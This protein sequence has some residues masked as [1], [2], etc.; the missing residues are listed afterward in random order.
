M[1]IL[2]LR[3]KNL[4]SLK[5]EFSIDFTVSPFKD[6][7]LFAITGATGAGKTT[8]LDAICLALYHRTPRMETISAATNEL[9][10]RGTADCLAEVEFEVKGVRYRA[11]WSQRRAHE[12]VD[13]ALQQPKVELADAAGAILADKVHEKKNRIE[14]ITGLS[15][16]RFTK[17]VLL[18]QGGFA[19][20]LNAKANERSELLEQLTGTDIYSRISQQVFTRTRASRDH[21]DQLEE[22]SRGME[23]L[24]DEARAELSTRRATLTS[25]EADLNTQ[26]ATTQEQLQWREAL[27]NA[28]AGRQSA[29]QRHRET[30]DALAHA[31]P[32]LD[33]LAASRPAETLRPLHQAL[34]EAKSARRGAEQ[35][36]ARHLA[37]QQE[38]DVR[39]A[40]ETKLAAQ[41]ATRVADEHVQRCEST[42]QAIGRLQ[43]YRENHAS[44]AL[45][46]QHLGAWSLQ[47]DGLTKQEST[48]AQLQQTLAAKETEEEAHHHARQGILVSHH[49]KQGKLEAAR[50][51]VAALLEEQ[52]QLLAGRSEEALTQEW[53][54]RLTQ[55]AQLEQLADV[56]AE[57]ARL[58]EASAEMRQREAATENE[59]L[60]RERDSLA[61]SAVHAN[62]QSQMAD[63]KRLLAQEQLIKS[64]DVHREQLQ[65]GEECPLCGSQEHPAIADYKA[66]NVTETERSLAAKEKELE[67]ISRDELRLKEE[68][69]QLDASL[70]LVRAQL[71]ENETTTKRLAAQTADLVT[72]LQLERADTSAIAKAREAHA[73]ALARLEALRQ[74]VT[75]CRGRHT[76]ADEQCRQLEQEVARLTAQVAVADEKASA[77]RAQV[78]ELA[79][80]R[81][82]QKS[83]LQQ[84]KAQLQGAL[85]AAGYTFPDD[86]ATWLRERNQDKETWQ[87]TEEELQTHQAN[88]PL[89]EAQSRQAAQQAD[90]LIADWRALGQGDLPAGPDY[91][92]S[93]A[94]LERCIA[95]LQE[96]RAQRQRLQGG[97]SARQQSLAQAQQAH[98]Q[99]LGE[100]QESLASSD[101]ADE[102]TFL[103][104]LLPAERREALT[105]LQSRLEKEEAAALA[106]ARQAAAACER[107]QAQTLTDQDAHA[108]K[109]QVE[110]L[111]DQR[112]TLAMQQGRI[113]EAL[114]ADAERRERQAALLAEIAERRHDAD[115]WDHLNGLI[116]SSDGAK[117]RRFAQGLTLDHLVHLANRQLQRLH[118]RY[119]LQ[120]RNTGELELE[121]VDTW[122]GDV[123]RDTK[124]LSGGES[125]LVSLALALALSDLVSHKTS[126]DSLFLDEGF[127]TLDSETLEV[128][129]A[130]LDNLNASGKTI[131][132][133]SHIEAM[134]ERINVQIRVQKGQGVGYS[135]LEV[136]S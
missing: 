47:F 22:K 84:E 64:L 123:A 61:L 115:L 68:A 26:L 126:I 24:S 77:L 76:A 18:A 100:F 122:Q 114:K 101:F 132:V 30:L 38:I 45:L 16:E 9:M 51:E 14:E 46:G 13:G 85:A 31:G 110:A 3:L 52:R 112:R 87:R 98:D 56:T 92:D 97:L 108:L 73:S 136:V 67:A 54:Q 29:E 89:Q 88:L 8:I 1:K 83:T 49:E 90:G 69:L 80:R 42:R 17:S 104:A 34:D 109:A 121:V 66:L 6:N 106:L 27:D 11:F 50:Q 15:F 113:A 62:L 28:E 94:R 53:Q 35:A 59:K 116:G 65:P 7:G 91:P 78:E 82:V 74:Q 107:L 117:F 20:F 131:G 119:M 99:R 93:A 102:A 86:A 120:R 40:Q 33:A 48:L 129:L 118:G 130:A 55:G 134:K 21:L 25:Q 103:A 39:L 12:K 23:V 41:L 81:D 105:K 70:S 127:G 4:N 44:H 79:Q 60:A 63:K 32:E 128:A 10:T 37:E 36:V 124:T 43:Q 125:F 2:R 133:I 95:T 5:G 111:Q 72:A 57:A 135:R 71:A 75:A 19:A 58:A 96:S